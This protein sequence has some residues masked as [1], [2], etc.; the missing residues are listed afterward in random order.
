MKNALAVFGLL[1]ISCGSP[2]AEPAALPRASLTAPSPTEAASATRGIAG[3]LPGSAVRV[4]VNGAP[5][6]QSAGLQLTPTGRPVVI[7]MTFPFAVDRPLLETWLPRNAA[8]MWIDDRTVRLTY[9]ETETNIG[10]KI[11]ETRAADGSAT[12]SFFIL[13]VDF[14]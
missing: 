2:I 9:A 12:I 7:E 14:P 5:Y 4:T 8:P 10:F 1:V 13:R 3:A 11:P 6:D